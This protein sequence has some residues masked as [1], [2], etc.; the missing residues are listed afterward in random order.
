M[1]F[2]KNP[3]HIFLYVQLGALSQKILVQSYKVDV[4]L[5]AMQGKIR[6]E[7]SWEH[8][9]G[10]TIELNSPRDISAAV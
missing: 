7:Q 3:V 4:S 5:K 9:R 1:W 8:F 2:G 10:S 6:P